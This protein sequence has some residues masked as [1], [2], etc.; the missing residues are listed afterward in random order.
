MEKKKQVWGDCVGK[1]EGKRKVGKG[2]SVEA[3]K[4]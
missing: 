4:G 3:Q 1:M 2:S